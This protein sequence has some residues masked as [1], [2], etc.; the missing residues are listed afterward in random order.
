MTP[1]RDRPVCGRRSRRRLG[2][3]VVR[4]VFA[5]GVPTSA[6]SW[7]GTAPTRRDQRLL[8]GRGMSDTAQDIWGGT[9]ERRRRSARRRGLT[10]EQLL[11]ELD[12]KD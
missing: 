4:A 12:A 1:E 7:R 6:G 9:N 10:A 5:A 3:V 8:Q 2:L 11:A